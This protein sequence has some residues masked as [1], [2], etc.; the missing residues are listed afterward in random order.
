MQEDIPEGSHSLKS[1][2][3]AINYDVS[4][5]TKENLGGVSSGIHRNGIILQQS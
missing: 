1:R 4:L 3:K 2:E 5:L